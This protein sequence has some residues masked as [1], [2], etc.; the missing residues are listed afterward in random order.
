MDLRQLLSSITPEV[1]ES[2]RR[3]VEVGKWPD[4]R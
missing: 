4:R 2:L 3:A 1:Y